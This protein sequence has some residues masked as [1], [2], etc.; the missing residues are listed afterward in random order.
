MSLA[1][2]LARY[3]DLLLLPEDVR[4]E[5]LGGV[6]TALLNETAVPGIRP[7]SPTIPATE[8]AWIAL[9]SGGIMAR[10][11]MLALPIQFVMVVRDGDAGLRGQRALGAPDRVPAQ[12]RRRVRT[13]HRRGN[14]GSPGQGHVL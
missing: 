3:A 8:A 14:Q 7:H 6:V 10:A 12:A 4:A 5:I 1:T 9:P 11:A 13:K 2:K